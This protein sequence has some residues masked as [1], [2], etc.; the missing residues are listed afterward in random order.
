MSGLNRRRVL[1]GAAGALTATGIAATAGTAGSKSAAAAEAGVAS[2]PFDP[3]KI[4]PDDLRYPDLTR[5]MNQ[6]WRSKP[7]HVRMA[8]T[9]DQVVGAVQEAVNANKRVTVQGGGHCYAD[10][11]HNPDVDVVINLSEMKNVHFDQQRSAFAVEAGATLLELYET[12]FKIWGVTVPGGMCFSVG[13]GGHVSGGGY[14]LLSRKH[15]LV[16]DHLHAVEVVTVDASGKAK[17]VVATRDADDP[18]RDLWWAHTGGGGGNF[19]VITRYWFRSPGAAGTDPGALLPRPPETL[20]VNAVSVSWSELDEASFTRMVR[21]YGTWFANNS[22]PDA[23]G[24]SLS[25]FLMVNHKA[26]GSAG[27]LTVVDGTD[28]DA[29]ALLRDYLS[30]LFDGTSVQTRPMSEPVGEMS[31]APELYQ[32]MR[33]PWYRAARLLGTNNPTL[34]DP[35]MRGEYKS[36]YLKNGFSDAQI[37]TMYE[38]L[39]RSDHTNPA[40]IMVLLSYGGR[41]N[42]VPRESTASAQRDSAFKMLVE[43]FW[44]DAAEDSANVDWCRALYN[45]VFADSGGY[46]VPNSQTD[47]CYINYPDMDITDPTYNGSGIPWHELYYKQNYPEL[48]RI[49]K[50]YDPNNFFR[51]S[52]SIGLPSA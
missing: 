38:Q 1:A 41:I 9:T 19:G 21:N 40:S 27:L 34:N 18:N 28:P 2:P 25:S 46:P 15:G 29:D 20:L 24:T 49:K 48:Q 35:T 52:Q 43:S 45:G 22:S 44:S 6:R 37:A 4:G 11:V 17:P 33:L 5:G 7:E 39:T 13:V 51:H 50:K 47:G 16:V 3:V 32:P 31:P 26:N 23:A 42:S 36:G 8:A 14:G 10:F 30:K 12:L